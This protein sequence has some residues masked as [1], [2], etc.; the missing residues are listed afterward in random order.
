[1]GGGPDESRLP[2]ERGVVVIMKLFQH[3]PPKQP[4]YCP[5]CG[6]NLVVREM[7]I[8]GLLHRFLECSSRGYRDTQ[9]ASHTVV[10]LGGRTIPTSEESS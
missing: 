1:M 3:Q 10:H 6:G 5:H 2:E 7:E 4:E 9:Y 8:D